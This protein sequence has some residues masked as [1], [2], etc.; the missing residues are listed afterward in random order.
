MTDEKRALTARE[1]QAKHR[2]EMAT[3]GYKTLSLGLVKEKYHDALKKLAKQLDDGTFS[4]DLKTRTVKDTSESDALRDQ[5]IRLES[6]LATVKDSL[7]KA[8]AAG[9]GLS[10]RLVK[11]N[12]R[13]QRYRKIWWRI[14]WFS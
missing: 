1:R 2:A 4:D 10:E 8:E 3:K 6:E 7:C 12:E 11:Q 5:I 9:K 14:W 13:M